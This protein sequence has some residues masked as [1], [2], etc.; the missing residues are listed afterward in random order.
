M[1]KFFGIFIICFKFAYIA[2]YMNMSGKYF[3]VFFLSLCIF[4]ASNVNAQTT[5][6]P[7]A[8]PWGDCVADPF[9]ECPIDGGIGLLIFAGIALGAK[10]RITNKV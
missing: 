9:Q 6:P 1:K 4:F 10:R 5:D 8:D 2:V 7:P 3:M